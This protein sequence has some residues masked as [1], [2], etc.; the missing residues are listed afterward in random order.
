MTSRK[1]MEILSTIYNFEVKDVNFIKM[2]Y[3]N[4]IYE[5]TP[6]LMMM[7]WLGSFCLSNKLLLCSN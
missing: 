4:E 5:R 2:Q 1:A 7:D 3:Y 6:E